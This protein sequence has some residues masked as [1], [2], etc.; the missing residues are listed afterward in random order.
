[1]SLHTAIVIDDHKNTVELLKLCLKK[2]CHSIKEVYGST[3]VQ[4]GF[5]K[6][7]EYEP[8]IIFLDVM[9]GE[10]TAFNLL[11][12]LGNIDS[13]I[14]FI[15]SFKE[16]ALKAMD[17]EV[18]NYLLK[19]IDIKKLVIAVRKVSEKLKTKVYMKEL[20]QNEIEL[21]DF[22]NLKDYSNKSVIAIAS[23]AKIELIKV[24]E[25]IFCEAERSYTILYLKDGTSKVSSKNL[26]E[27]EN[28]L[29]PKGAFFRI[30]RKYLVNLHMI[31]NINKSAGNYCEMINKKSLPISKRKREKLFKFLGIS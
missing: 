9:I 20:L 10:D 18:S 3:D 13:E 19:P 26:L 30:H 23:T 7:Q 8:D 31:E 5:H 28:L 21:K 29:V 22:N 27:Y 24:E 16:F 11:D 15:S 14:I 12:N 6:I 25:I 1:M 2:Y 17:Y 4:D